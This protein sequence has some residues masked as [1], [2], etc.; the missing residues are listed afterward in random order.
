M[1]YMAIF[2]I[3][4]DFEMKAEIYCFVNF[5]IAKYG[6]ICIIIRRMKWLIFIIFVLDE[7]RCNYARKKN[8]CVTLPQSARY[9]TWAYLGRYKD[10]VCFVRALLIDDLRTSEFTARDSS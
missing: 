5:I 9:G 6:T 2:F 7:N 8:Y 3:L 1:F 10:D 4:R